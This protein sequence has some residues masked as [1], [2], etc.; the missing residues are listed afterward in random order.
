MIWW[1]SM[2]TMDATIQPFL[3]STPYTLSAGEI[4]LQCTPSQTCLIYLYCRGGAD[5][6][7]GLACR[8]AWHTNPGYAKSIQ[9]AVKAAHALVSSSPCSRLPLGK[10]SWT[11]ML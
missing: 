11:R 1:M 9:A 3:G 2:M 7:C 8:I 6:L 4:Q 10:A 5:V